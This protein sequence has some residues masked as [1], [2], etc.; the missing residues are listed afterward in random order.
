[1]NKLVQELIRPFL[2]EV[3]SK[4]DLV[5]YGGGFKPPT[6]GHLKTALRAYQIPAKKHQIVVGGGVRDKIT[7]DSSIKI[8]QL[9][10]N[11]EG[12]PTDIEI[13][14]APSPVKYTLDL[15][16]DNPDLKIA[17]IAGVRD[18]D[19]LVSAEKLKSTFA[20][21]GVEVEIISDP[22]SLVSGTKVRGAFLSKDKD[23]FLKL[24]PP[25]SGEEIWNILTRALIP[26]IQEAKSKMGYRAGAFNPSQ[27][28][29]RLKDKGIGIVKSKVGLLGT[30]HYFMGNLD[31]VKRL[32]DQLGYTTLSQIDLSQYK[33]FR[34]DDPTG[35]YENI[36]AVTSY[37]HGL[38]PEDLQDSTVKD[39]I[40]DAA[41]G[42]AEYIGLD[43]KETLN[44]FKEYIKDV[45]SR[46]DGDLLSNRLLKDYDGIDLTNTP[47]D[48]FGTGSL[49]FNGKLK[50]G[51]YSELESIEEKVYF[52]PEPNIGLDDVEFLDQFADNKLAP[53]DI[54]LSGQHFIDRLNDPRNNPEIEVEE[55]EDFFDKLGD[56]KEEFIDL[57]DD[58][59]EVVA[60]DRQTNLNIPFKGIRNKA[61]AKTI[62]RK[63]NF[64]TSNPI[65][66][67]QEGRY[68]NEVLVQSRYIINQFKAN[69]GIKYEEETGGNIEGIEYA[70]IF[71]FIPSKKLG[72]IPFIVEGEADDDTV[73][74]TIRYNTT[75]FPKEYNNLIAEVKETLRHELEHMA[76]LNFEKGVRVGGQSQGRMPLAQYLT[77]D[78]EV[79]AFVQGLYKRAKTKKIS[80]QQAIDEF[81]NERS[82][83]L[84]DEEETNVKRVWGRWIR[85]NLPQVKLN[86]SVKDLRPKIDS[87]LKKHNLTSKELQDQLKKGVKVEKEHTSSPTVAMKIALDHI[88]EN[89]K[90]YDILAKAKLEELNEVDPKVGTGKKP[91]GSG[92][93]L[94]TDEN[95]KDTVGIKFKTKEDIVTTLNKN[96]FKSKPH[97]RQSQ[98]INV[99]HQRVR[100]AY[101]RTQD[102]EIKARLKKALDYAEER[103]EKS[104]EKTERLRLQK[105]NIAP[106]HNNKAA[107]YGSGYKPLKEELEP[108]ILDFTSFLVTN[109]MKLHPFPKIKFIEDDTENANNPL[110][111]TAYYDPQ[112][113]CIT[114]YTLNRHP[115]DILRSYSH[116]LVHHMQ[117]I[118]DRLKPMNTSNVYEDEELANIEK[119]AHELGS[120][121]LRKWEDSLKTNLKEETNPEYKI[122]S[123]MDGVITD[124]DTQFEKLSGGISPDEY[125]KKN[126]KEAFWKL[127]R[128]KGVGFW[129]GMPWMSDGLEYWNYIKQ[130]NPTLLSAPSKD[131]SSRLGKRLW[132]KNNI[133]GTK[134][135]LAY[136][137]DKQKYAAPNHILIDDR[138]S[139]I[140]QWRSQ[141]GIGILHTSA[142]NTIQ[143]LKELGL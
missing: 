112:A 59:E 2:G 22:S 89:P 61:I 137:Q 133:P 113:K 32:Q 107:P 21:A 45:M 66:S 48:D 104:K 64:Q 143:Q 123:D 26:E 90:Y 95:P 49:I 65:L 30:G 5:V 71:K 19:D 68:D 96:S 111:K 54:D 70:L 3:E 138:P 106:N 33:L 63:S 27:P 20:K 101:N 82:G 102:P 125:E 18:N 134:L 53:L 36:K 128:D 105:E 74:I 115:K 60:K 40:K 17:F 51:T 85:L 76:Q 25:N 97:A 117:N 31:D 24:M 79:P 121:N 140:E 120:M 93:R 110:G 135:I 6:S 109:G 86:E 136:A 87:I 15:A 92:R 114:L 37:L 131:E 67:L 94:Y 28:A 62:M 58:N 77:L 73:E 75:S 50:K 119:E 39:D 99:I 29:E 43:K 55:L 91:K 139:N 98:I 78:Y 10:Q 142:A 72:P 130:Y 52:K 7:S 8:W 35:F 103:K 1:M 13:L 127:I 132:V 47:Y 108:L 9:Y 88:A 83:E 56:R 23:T 42:F 46:K 80:L 14:Q 118:E 84:T 11:K 4:Y 57:L 34:P 116:E 100:A 69:F 81:F 16:K 122:Y 12:L 129:V 126:G 44:I 38:K 41:D 124:F 141:G